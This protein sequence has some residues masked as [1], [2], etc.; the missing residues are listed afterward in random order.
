MHENKRHNQ[1]YILIKQIDG[2]K[3][4][5]H[6]KLAPKQKIP[7]RVPIHHLAAYKGGQYLDNPQKYD[8]D[9]AKIIIIVSDPHKQ[10]LSIKY[11]RID[12]TKLI[13]TCQYYTDY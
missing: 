6:T 13:R 1:W 12:T 4:E 2:R 7:L 8:N 5:H 3:Y 9:L 11:N 10:L